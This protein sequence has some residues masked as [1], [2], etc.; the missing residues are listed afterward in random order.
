MSVKFIPPYTPILYSKKGVFRG[1][2]IFL[3]FDPK[4]RLW[5]LIRTASNDTV[6]T[7]NILN[8]NI[9]NIYFFSNE[10]WTSFLNVCAVSLNL[11][12]YK[13]QH[14]AEISIDMKS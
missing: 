13:I 8:T 2:A 11:I 4:H 14:F 5:V 3:I 10:E 9:I 1:I 7:I 6:P 12:S